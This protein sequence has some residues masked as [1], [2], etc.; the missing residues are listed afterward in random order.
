MICLSPPSFPSSPPS[1]SPSL[2]LSLPPPLPSTCSQVSSHIQVLA[3]KKAREIQGKIKVC[4]SRI[5]FLDWPGDRTAFWC[6]NKTFGMV[7]SSRGG[8]NITESCLWRHCCYEYFLSDWEM[9]VTDT[10][11]KWMYIT[12]FLCWRSMYDKGRL[13]YVSNSHLT[14]FIV[15]IEISKHFNYPTVVIICHWRRL[16]KSKF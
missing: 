16:P 12:G 5:L 10:I 7:S 3:R 15:I 8:W 6:N 2:S 1:P 14:Q 13:V 4:H 11:G 9:K